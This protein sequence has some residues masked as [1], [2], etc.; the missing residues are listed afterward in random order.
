MATTYLVLGATGMLGSA[1]LKIFAAD[2]ST[3]FGTVRSFGALDLFP[4]AVRPNL[5][6]G[7]DAA[8]MDSVAHAFE[9]SR[10]DVVVNCIGMV[11]QLAQSKD[12]LVALPLNALF[13]HRLMR[14]CGAT[15]AR[16]V[17]VSTDC[18]FTGD[19]GLYSESDRPD[20]DDLYGVSKRLGEV[21]ALHAITLRTS[22]IGHELTGSRSLIDWFL[23]QQGPVNG[24]TKA[25][26]S[27]LP[28]VE[29]AAVIRDHVVPRPELHGLYHVSAQ[30]IDKFTLLTL[31]AE[32]YGK[33]VEIVPSESLVI[34]RSL[35]SDR[36][37][38][39]TGW[40]PA[41]WPELVARMRALTPGAETR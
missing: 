35:N 38:T 17:H 3:V 34:D 4:D 2:G 36:F 13:P 27:G 25:V 33:T 19:A 37:R 9:V 40:S 41:P 6:V 32:A 14:L 1:C 8:D 10:P 15:G 21:D 11:K 18:V 5:I 24:F 16:L 20:A 28:T 30:P 39:A 12:P 7:V 22:I 26:F 23:S 29:L 31:V